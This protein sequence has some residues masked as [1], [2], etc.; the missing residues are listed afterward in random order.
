MPPTLELTQD[1]K[2]GLEPANVPPATGVT[3]DKYGLEPAEKSQT[4]FSP[5][6][7]QARER[8]ARI[9][10]EE[11]EKEVQRQPTLAKGAPVQSQESDIPLEP[12]LLGLQTIP[13]LGVGEEI[14]AHGLRATVPT[15]MRLG[16]GL[17][18]A[19]IGGG[20]GERGGRDVGSL[21]GETGQQVGGA[22]GAIGGGLLGGGLAAGLER[23]PAS[24][25]QSRRGIPGPIRSLPFGIQRFIPEWM[26]PK[27]E[28][29]S[30]TNPGP[31]AELPPRVPKPTE[32]PTNPFGGMT[33]SATPIGTAEVP[34]VN[35]E[36]KPMA[37]PIVRT[38]AELAAAAKPKEL[39]KPGVE[40]GPK[41]ESE[42]RPATWSDDAVLTLASKG[43]RAAIAQ[44]GVRGLAEKF[45]GDPR[46]TNIRYVMGDVDYRNLITSPR[47]VTRFTPEGQPIRQEV[48]QP[49]GRNVDTVAKAARQGPVAP[50]T[51]P[52]VT[53][54]S[55]NFEQAIPVPS[56]TVAPMEKP[57]LTVD[58]K[59]KTAGVTERRGAPRLADVDIMKTMRMNNLRA[60]IAKLPEGDPQRVDME[61]LLADMIAHP[62]ESAATEL[63]G[64]DI[65]AMKAEG[66]P[67]LSREQAEANVAARKVG[68]RE[69]VLPGMEGDVAKQAEGAARVKGEELTAEMNRPKNVDEAAGHL[70][71][72]GELFRGTAASPQG[73]LLRPFE[74]PT[75]TEPEEEAEPAEVKGVTEPIK[76]KP[77]KEKF[78]PV[79][80]RFPD[81]KIKEAEAFIRENIEKMGATGE[82]PGHYPIM[83]SR[84]GNLNQN[85]QEI[86]G[87]R[88]SK[89][90]RDTLPW[91]KEN[92][93]FNPEA[94]DKAL[95]NRDSA[96]RQ[97]AVE[98]AINFL[99]RQKMTPEEKAAA[100]EK[101]A[102]KWKGFR[103]Q[104]TKF[105]KTD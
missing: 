53:G 58:E 102:E 68:G 1:D 46:L 104:P 8:I 100:G 49:I 26:V 65:N 62:E 43:N 5:A 93:K 41:I 74:K 66:K 59:L 4:E 101:I 83:E 50:M 99:D 94:L 86:K 25:L 6:V 15:I 19:S 21:F 22:I 77:A 18:G 39:I 60:E 67:T 45:A 103:P 51:P 32:T 81:E 27:G 12:S 13:A 95:H 36:V 56:E 33:S 2:Y 31:F 70:E 90:M 16:R 84:E 42:G 87:W 96:L 9:I 44:V 80:K 20:L 11:E 105:L 28:L 64:K 10:P 55:L 98:S 37:P 24:G 73:E 97:R 29:G 91:M 69:G 75:I 71:T 7:K 85:W 17:I 78:V 35:P 76:A 79:E 3:D 57:R 38:R 82:K 14:A 52:K 47:E 23:N 88:G 89:S 40:T 48:A 30:P 63:G 72:R 54:P 34:K 92:P 61:H